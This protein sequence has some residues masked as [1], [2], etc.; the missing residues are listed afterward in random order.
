MKGCRKC[1]PCIAAPVVYG[2]LL[3]LCLLPFSLSL[4][5]G[6]GKKSVLSLIEAE[7]PSVAATSNTVE[8]DKAVEKEYAT[9]KED[10]RTL[11]KNDLQTEF[12]EDF[13]K[14]GA[15]LSDDLTITFNNPAAL[16]ATGGS[17]TSPSFGAT[18]ANLSPRYSKVLEKYKEHIT[19]MRVE[20][21]TS[22]EWLGSKTTAEAF[23]KNTA[24]SQR[25]ADTAANKLKGTWMQPILSS[26]G[27][28]ST[29]LITNSDGS[30]NPEASRRVEIHLDIKDATIEKQVEVTK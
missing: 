29:N 25:R 3:A 2:T 30:E 1:T 23:A 26:K 22:S 24:L 17:D 9:I 28:A 19:G 21:H 11:I 8:I 10:V 27:L 15:S 5:G 7:V 14:W 16:F 12:G 20:G 18:L 6:S 4:F 13:T